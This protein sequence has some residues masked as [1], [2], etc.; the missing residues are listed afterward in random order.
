L[1]TGNKGLIG[2]AGTGH[3]VN[4]VAAMAIFISIKG[5]QDDIVVT[6]AA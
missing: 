6:G 3:P 2:G 1:V 4:P 5:M